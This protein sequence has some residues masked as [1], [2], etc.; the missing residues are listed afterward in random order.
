MEAFCYRWTDHQEEKVYVGYHAGDITDGYISSSKVLNHLID[1]RPQTFTREI[2]SEGTRGKMYDYETKILVDNNAKY[3]DKFYNASNN[4]WSPPHE[5]AGTGK[6]RLKGSDRTEEQTRGDKSQAQKLSVMAGESRSLAQ[7]E[8][9]YRLKTRT[10]DNH[11]MKGK[12]FKK[13]ASTQCKHC[14]KMFNKSA[15]TR[16][17]GDNCKSIRA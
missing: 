2:L 10:G 14:E 3:N 12:T 15:H 17:H 1:F 16:F 8:A 5:V 9:D 6:V 4:E 13:Q 11:P 7:R